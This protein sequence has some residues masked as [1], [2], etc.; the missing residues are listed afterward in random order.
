MGIQLFGKDRILVGELVPAPGGF[1]IRS[2][3][4]EFAATIGFAT[5]VPLV[6]HAGLNRN[7]AD[8]FRS[9]LAKV[10]LCCREPPC[11]RQRYFHVRRE[12]KSTAPVRL[13]RLRYPFA[14]HSPSLDVCKCC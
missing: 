9:K 2:A 12:D 13:T 6:D 14:C 11:G 7:K 5:V 8:S 1:G 3:C 10:Y 4:R